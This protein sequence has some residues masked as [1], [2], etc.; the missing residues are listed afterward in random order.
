MTMTTKTL[1]LVL[2]Y[3]DGKEI[4]AATWDELQHKFSRTSGKPVTIKTESNGCGTVTW[5]HYTLLIYRTGHQ[6]QVTVA[7]LPLGCST[8]LMLPS[9]VDPR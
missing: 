1:D 9:G 5:Y 2:R 4:H 8:M 6:V 7:Y 3:G